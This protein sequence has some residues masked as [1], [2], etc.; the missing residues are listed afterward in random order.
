MN[1]ELRSCSSFVARPRSAFQPSD[2]ISRSRE[3]IAMIN[4]VLRG[5]GNY[6]RTGNAANPFRNIDRYLCDRLRD[7]RVKRASRQLQ[8]GDAE[9]WTEDYFHGLGLHRLR[10]T[11]Q[12]PEVA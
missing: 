12:Y 8:A 6:F 7:L 1:D 3:V 11:I 10:G 9:R 4:P 5:S 2:L